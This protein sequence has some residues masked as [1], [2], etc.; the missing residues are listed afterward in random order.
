MSMKSVSPQ[1]GQVL[2]EYATLTPEQLESRLSASQAAFE[3]Y[4]LSSPEDRTR[5]MMAAADALE[6][7]REELAVLATQE[8]GKTVESARQ[9]VDKCAWVCRYYAE[10]AAEF[11]AP[12]PVQTAAQSAEVR[13]LPLG[14]VLAVMPWNFPYWQVF[15][16]A[17]PT[18]M[19]G[20]TGLLKHASNVPGCALAIEE[21]FTE[22]GFPAGVFQTLL[23][24][25]RDVEGVLRDPRV[26]AVSLTG[27]EGAGRAVA[28]TAGQEIKPAVM[29]LGGSDP[30]IVMPS[31]DLDL[32]VQTAVNARTLNNGQS[33]I[34]AKRFLVH[35]DIY[36]AFEAKFVEKLA[37]LRLGDPLE[38]GTDVG[39]LATAS[40]RD[41]LHEQVQDAVSKG[42]RLL[43]GGELPSGGAGYHYPV[44]ALADL[45]P[46]M[47]VW[48]EETFGPV[49]LLFRV[50]DIDHALEIANGTR[51]GLSSSA[52][53]Q[54]S[55]EQERFIRD[56]DAG[57]TFINA[58]S[59]SDPRLAFG[60]VKASGFGRELGRE[61]ILAFVN[62]KAVSIGMAAGAHHSKTE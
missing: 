36:S 52:W 18:L 34:A 9:E 57:A 20:N 42:A 48:S 4:R 60:G 44:T 14:P 41:E 10:H 62:A 1:T 37:A 29:E 15:R 26:R 58:M 31:A 53:T 30:F 3:S 19:A 5:W 38:E 17:A 40:I 51:F 11:L 28:G 23:I 49:A 8:M 54:D 50:R 12:Q 24:G 39:P 25:S 27:S 13:Y 32:A 47:Q 22:A 35:T 43:L 45:T 46:E 55:A 7:R 61:G 21:I 59:V 6:S 56:L 33:C 16:F 2:Q